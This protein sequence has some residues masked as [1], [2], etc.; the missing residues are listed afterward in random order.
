MTFL[1]L[2]VVQTPHQTEELI[3]HGREELL[4]YISQKNPNQCSYR[5]VPVYEPKSETTGT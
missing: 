2:L 5:A 4:K 3:F 1:W